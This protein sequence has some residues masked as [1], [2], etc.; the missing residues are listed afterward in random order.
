L[1]KE[2]VWKLRDLFKEIVRDWKIQTDQ[3]VPLFS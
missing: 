3:L 2:A 1:D